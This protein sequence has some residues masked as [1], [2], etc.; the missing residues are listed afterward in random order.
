MAIGDDQGSIP[1]R[2]GGII[3][4]PLGLQE[5]AQKV[6]N[7]ENVKH[8]TLGPD[9]T[10]NEYVM[11][12]LNE[13]FVGLQDTITATDSFTVTVHDRDGNDITRC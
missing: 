2:D 13:I 7:A 10:T 11:R 6:A 1:A 9:S 3:V 12:F 4:S 8:V 5:G